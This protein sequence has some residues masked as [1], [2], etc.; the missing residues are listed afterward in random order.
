MAES[1]GRQHLCCDSG[2]TCAFRRRRWGLRGRAAMCLCR[3]A[4]RETQFAVH[5]ISNTGRRGKRLFNVPVSTRSVDWRPSGR[6]SVKDTR[7]FLG[8]PTGPSK[9]ED[10]MLGGTRKAPLNKQVE[11]GSLCHGPVV[12]KSA[13]CRSLWIW[14]M[15]LIYFEIA[16]GALLRAAWEPS[17]SACP[18]CGGEFVGEQFPRGPNHILS[19]LDSVRHF[20][21]MLY[22]PGKNGHILALWGLLPMA[23]NRHERSM[24]M[25]IDM[26]QTRERPWSSWH[27]AGERSAVLPLR[28][29]RI[30]LFGR[31]KVPC[32]WQ[33]ELPLGQV[34]PTQGLLR[35]NSG[36]FRPHLS[37][38][39]DAISE[40]FKLRCAGCA[41]VGR[42]ARVPRARALGAR[43]DGGPLRRWGGRGGVAMSSGG[44][45]C[46]RDL[47]G[48]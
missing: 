29:R 18:E 48:P 45:A 26:K 30:R 43:H 31:D 36:R 27:H 6:W 4:W 37:C 23:G 46:P 25:S 38:G 40:S 44:G 9:G 22:V 15:C 19:T 10:N 2:V 41:A 5:L 3:E 17:R 12:P 16:P 34:R 42:A 20:Q 39:A 21:H 8:L 32:C 24:I 47:R 14:S 7:V 28:P 1:Q 35:P 11:H 33:P 13:Q